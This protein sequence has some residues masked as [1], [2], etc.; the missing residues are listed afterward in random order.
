MKV[1]AFISGKGGVGKTTLAANVAIALAQQGKKVLLIDLDMQN[2]LRLH[3]AM[4]PLDI[5]GVVRDGISPG[6]SFRSPFGVTFIPFG[7]AQ[8]TELEEFETVLKQHPTWILDRIASLERYAIDFVVLD[9]PPGSSVF[10]RQALMTAHLAIGVV[11]S[12]A[13]SFATIPRLFALVN[14][15]TRAR[16]DFCGLNLLVNQ[17]SD[18]S[19]LCVQVRAALQADYGRSLVPIG[20]HRA[21]AAAEALAFEQPLLMYDSACRASQDITRLARWLID[22]SK[23]AETGLR[24][25]VLS[26]R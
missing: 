10:L 5:A 3:L 11:L 13:A 26:L 15:Y 12:D 21:A 6:S 2:A 14:E 24:H 4:D 8:K 16:D 23:S 18:E 17:V 1:V 20:V 22:W 9:T 7:T 19:Q 25:D